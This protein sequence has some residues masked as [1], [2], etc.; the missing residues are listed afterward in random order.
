[1]VILALSAPVRYNI[2]SQGDPLKLFLRLQLMAS[3]AQVDILLECLSWY[4]G[5]GKGMSSTTGLSSTPSGVPLASDGLP[6]VS[7]VNLY[8]S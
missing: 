1:M 4:K 7:N 5:K 2:L 6:L 3:T 8:H